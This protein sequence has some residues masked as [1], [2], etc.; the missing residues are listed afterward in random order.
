[1]TQNNPITLIKIAVVLGR[2]GYSSSSLYNRI[3][4]GVFCPPIALG[5][6]G[7][8]FVESEVQTVLAAMVSGKNKETIQALVKKLVEQRQ[9]L[10]K[11]VSL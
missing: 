1:M 3:N 5:P 11:G 7:V 4:E 6:R 10:F 8:A 9:G 2:T